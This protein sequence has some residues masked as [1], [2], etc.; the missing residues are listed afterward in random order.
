[1][2]DTTPRRKRPALVISLG[3]AALVVLLGASSCNEVPADLAQNDPTANANFIA[4]KHN[5]PIP[6][7]ERS[8]ERANIIE[9]LKRNNEPERVRYVYLLTQ[10]GA[11]VNYHIAKGKLTSAGAQLTPTDS[12]VDVCSATDYCPQV[13]QGQTDDGSFGGDEGGIYFFDDLGNEIQWNGLFYVSDIPR[14]IDPVTRMVV[15]N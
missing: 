5:N 14:K 11:V 10:T 15:L 9:H 4:Q 12:V 7:L 1:M 13:V 3:L 6:Q 2:T 8:L